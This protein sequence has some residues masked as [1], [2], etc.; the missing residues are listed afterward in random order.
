MEEK[1]I[2]LKITDN[3]KETQKNVQELKDKGNQAFKEK[4]YQKAI[5]FFTEAIE[6][7]SS[8]HITFSNRYITI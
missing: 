7:D 2:K 6:I 1:V 3:S 5:N 4:E 8:D